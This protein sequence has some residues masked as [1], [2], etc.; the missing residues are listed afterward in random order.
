MW[1]FQ[2]SKISFL[3]EIV[4]PPPF[5]KSQG[6]PQTFQQPWEADGRRV[7]VFGVTF[8][9]DTD[10]SQLETLAKLAGASSTEQRA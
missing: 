4:F 2:K 10:R 6:S 3:F 5:G 8:G 7:P 9:E 1:H